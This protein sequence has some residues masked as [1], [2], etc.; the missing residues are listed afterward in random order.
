MGVRENKVVTQLD[1]QVVKQLNGITRKWVSP[2]RVGVPDRIVLWPNYLST[3]F[4]EVKTT[5]GKLS[6]YQ[7]REHKRLR[8]AGALVFTVYGTHGVDVFIS[9]ARAG[10]LHIH[11]GNQDYSF[12]I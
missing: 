3:V 9:S 4:V 5:D 10:S 12:G 11:H 8:D 7:E 6:T 1:Q 2:G